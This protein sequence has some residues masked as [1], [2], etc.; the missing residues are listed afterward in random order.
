LL[1]L[2]VGGFLLFWFALAGSISLM[3]LQRK[4]SLPSRRTL[5]G[6]LIVFATLWFGVGLLAHFVWLPWLLI[7]KRL[8]LWPLGALLALPWFLAI[9]ETIR[10][11]G[12]LKRLLG[13]AL[14]TVVLGVGFVLALWLVPELFVL[15]LI[16]PVLPVVSGL[17]E[18][19]TARLR[20]SW[21]FAISGA[22]FMSWVLLAVFP[23]V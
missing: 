17:L 3:F 15:I 5:F 23:I 21:P 18:L 14:H 10:G 9:G 13:W 4:L 19:A 6:G 8:V 20:G 2:T 7:P 12:F 22:L 1:G 11:D 16:L